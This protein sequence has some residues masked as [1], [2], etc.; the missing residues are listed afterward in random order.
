[1]ARRAATL[2]LDLLRH[3]GERPRERRIDLGFE[4]KQRGSTARRGAAP[5]LPASAAARQS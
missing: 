3:S 4:I 5:S 2:I 1:M